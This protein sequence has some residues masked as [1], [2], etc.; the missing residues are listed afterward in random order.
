M[1]GGAPTGRGHNPNAEEKVM[2]QY[3]EYHKRITV[4]TTLGSKLDLIVTGR[5]SARLA[6]KHPVVA[7]IVAIN[8]EAGILSFRSHDGRP[9]RG[10]LT[11]HSRADLAAVADEVGRAIYKAKYGWREEYDRLMGELENAQYAD[12]YDPA[13]IVQAQKALDDYLASH[14]EVTKRLRAERRKNARHHWAYSEA[15]VER[16]LRG[17]D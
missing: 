8:P 14:P 16:A 3:E 2:A 1:A 7:E 4:T 17:E 11:S 9:G 12:Y 10:E 6:S 15:A 13:R 5:N